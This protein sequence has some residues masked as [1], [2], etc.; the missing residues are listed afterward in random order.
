MLGTIF[1]TWFIRH[2]R[3]G[4]DHLDEWFKIDHCKAGKGDSV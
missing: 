1:I 4:A 2:R 3:Y